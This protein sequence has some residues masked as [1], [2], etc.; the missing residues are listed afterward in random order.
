MEINSRLELE[1]TPS[2]LTKIPKTLQ[3]FLLNSIRNK[4]SKR[5]TV[6]IASNSLANRF[7]LEQWGIR[8]SQRRRYKNLYS[9]VR[10]RCRAIFHNYLARGRVEWVSEGE[11]MI[12]GLYKFDEIRGNIILVFVRITSET[13]W[14]LPR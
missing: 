13:D 3:S 11:R 9:L 2:I 7:I 8:A 6:L 5:K 10:H 4:T 14:S 12:F 1:A